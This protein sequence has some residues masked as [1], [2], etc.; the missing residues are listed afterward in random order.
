MANTSEA[1]NKASI[2]QDMQSKFGL[3]ESDT[4]STVVQIALLSSRIEQITAHIKEHKKDL[5]SRRGLIALVGQRRKL[6]KYLKNTS[7][8]SYTKLIADLGIRGK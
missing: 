1:L 8:E 5:H 6:L 3:S 2:V 4:G 7:L